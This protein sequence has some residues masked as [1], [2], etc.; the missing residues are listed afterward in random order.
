MKAQA[1][2]TRTTS[3]FHLLLICVVLTP[4]S[5]VSPTDLETPASHKAAQSLDS[6]AHAAITPEQTTIANNVA[7]HSSI[8]E[9]D[10]AHSLRSSS[11]V[12]SEA[13]TEP[14]SGIVPLQHPA[15][16]GTTGIDLSQLSETADGNQASS[17][18]G[19]LPGT[20]GDVAST[21]I[22]HVV[23]VSNQAGTQ[24]SGEAAQGGAAT[25]GKP[26]QPL[27]V[28][29]LCLPFHG[30]GASWP[31]SCCLYF[32]HEY[33]GLG[34]IR[35]G[36]GIRYQVLVSCFRNTQISVILRVHFDGALMSDARPCASATASP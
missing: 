29:N 10:I 26:G 35:Q 13:A 20:A 25:E 15:S 17:L 3:A 30:C 32:S 6:P 7:Q 22:G 24:S 12:G 28:P 11:N 18:P 23:N 19:K 14:L 8:G 1:H 36:L 2:R 16:G 4:R 33:V 9:S 5:I 31:G 21:L 34:C 27:Q